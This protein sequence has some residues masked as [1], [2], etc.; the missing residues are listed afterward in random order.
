MSLAVRML[1]SVDVDTCDRCGYPLPPEAKF[2]PNCGAPISA[3]EATERK[4]VTVVF[5]DLVGS[6]NLAGRLDPERFREVIAGFFRMASA[7]LTSLRGRAEKF[8]GDAVMA[9]FGVP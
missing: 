1:G 7:E 4:I 8:I 6:T 2:C 3:V 5:A 9:V